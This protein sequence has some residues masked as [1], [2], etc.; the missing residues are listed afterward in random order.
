MV[1][2]NKFLKTL[3]INKSDVLIVAVSYGPDSM[4]LLDII[5]KS[6]PN[7]KIVCAHVH[8][9][10]RKESDDESKKLKE[11]CEKRNFIFE[12]MKIKSYK[13]NKFTEEEARY[14]RYEF[15]ET[16]INKYNS[17]FLFTAHHGDDLIETI[18]MRITRGST[19]RG[20][21]GITLISNREN[22]NLIR[23][24]LFVTK[25]DLL[26]YCKENGIDYAVD[27]S[28]DDD[29][30]T[31]NRFRKYILPYFKQENPSVH[32]QFLKFSTELSEYNNYFNKLVDDLYPTI[33][34]K[35][36]I[37]IDELMKQ[38]TL[39][40][41][42]IIM[43][44][45]YENYKDEISKVGYENID[46]II[47]LINNGKPNVEIMLPCKKKLIRSYNKIYFAKEE[48]YNYYCFV[49]NE[50]RLLPNGFVI[51]QINTLENTTNFITAFNLDDL[52]L[53]L[54]VRN[55]TKGDK[56]EVLGLNG[57]KKIHDIFINE[58]LPK[59]SRENYP[60]LCDSS[61]KIIWLPGLKK[62]KYDKSKVGKYDIILKYYKEEKNDRTK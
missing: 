1:L 58:K 31:R 20:Y 51:E 55:V 44:F 14:K 26:K 46:S 21:C 42:R 11:F 37:N 23:P 5:G 15:F 35:N 30:Y 47:T 54:Y 7:N 43:K 48:K 33:V 3:N 39:I 19:L 34:S 16:L 62:S 24:L 52:C 22:Y 8:H 2:V 60:V 17:K 40:I 12:F 13:N 36:V 50:Y 18:L 9:N 41:K 53:P 57:S 27:K 56:I 49:F 29:K 10:H 25:D 4:A 28:N 61:G 6:Y 59:S 32:R 38:D 45:L